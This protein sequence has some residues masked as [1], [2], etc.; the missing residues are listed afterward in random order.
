MAEKVTAARTRIKD[1]LAQGH[2]TIDLPKDDSSTKGYL[3]GYARSV[4]NKHASRIS[5]GSGALGA[6]ITP[7]PGGGMVTS[8][9]INAIK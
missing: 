1:Y 8:P 7:G 3:D 5:L 6:T 4:T 2:K 9:S